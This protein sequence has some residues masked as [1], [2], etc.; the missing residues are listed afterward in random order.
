MRFFVEGE[1]IV[2]RITVTPGGDRDG[3]NSKKDNAGRPV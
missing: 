3:T 2:G 1:A